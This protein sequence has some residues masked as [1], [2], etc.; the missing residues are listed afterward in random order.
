M[1]GHRDMTQ[2][3]IQANTAARALP[4]IEGAIRNPDN[5]A[6]FMTARPI[7][8][9]LRA[10]WRKTLLCDTFAALQ[11]VEV[12]HIVYPPRLYVPL[13]HIRPRVTAGPIRTTCP[14]KGHA[15]YL[16]L[17]EEEIGWTYETFDFAAVLAGHAAFWDSHLTVELS[18]PPATKP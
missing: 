2:V 6:H 11:V 5:L 8:A 13:D 3:E 14:L 18:P 12:G 1:Q 17:G 7:G 9:R 10:W 16:S 15:R 4:G